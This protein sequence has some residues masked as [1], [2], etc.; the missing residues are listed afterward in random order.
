MFFFLG[1]C[2]SESVQGPTTV[3]DELVNSTQHPLMLH[4][5]KSTT[6]KYIKTLLELRPRVLLH[7]GTYKWRQ[8]VSES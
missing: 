1:W 7:H 8:A 5:N 4:M 3:A 2:Q 6:I